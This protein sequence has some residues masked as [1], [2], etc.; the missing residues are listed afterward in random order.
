MVKG[1]RTHEE[2][3]RYVYGRWTYGPHVPGHCA[4]RVTSPEGFW[5]HQCSRYSGHGPDGLFCKQHARMIA[6][7]GE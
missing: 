5:G 7:E 4:A 2:A 3:R 1:P 6:K